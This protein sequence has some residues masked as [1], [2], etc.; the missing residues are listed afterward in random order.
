M[1]SLQSKMPTAARGSTNTQLFMA[2][3][4][5]ALLKNHINH[6]IGGDST[7]SVLEGLLTSKQVVMVAQQPHPEIPSG[8]VK[9][10]PLGG[11]GVN[12]TMVIKK[13]DIDTTA[14][15]LMLSKQDQDLNVSAHSA[16]RQITR[17]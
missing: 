11:V 15:H 14:K 9:S 10:Q 13:T 4:D 8:S 5:P 12:Q 3:N 1:N 7:S 6:A 17:K 2:K 16:S